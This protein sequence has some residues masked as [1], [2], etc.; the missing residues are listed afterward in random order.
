M[1][2]PPF[3]YVIEY[4]PHLKKN[5]Y[6]INEE[7]CEALEDI[8]ESITFSHSLASIAEDLNKSGFQTR[9]E[10]R[11]SALSVR[12]IVKDPFYIN[13]IRT[14]K[15]G[16]TA[17]EFSAHPCPIRTEEWVFAQVMINNIDVLK[18][19]QIQ[20][21]LRNPHYEPCNSFF[22][23]VGEEDNTDYYLDLYD[24]EPE[25]PLV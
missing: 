24:E 6:V 22:E 7:E 11:F 1:K 2:Q 9:S 20:Q 8:F 17:Y 5:W 15:G 18:E 16:E 23:I 14:K 10:K 12:A 25:G 3:G 13:L 4:V 19:P 21:Q